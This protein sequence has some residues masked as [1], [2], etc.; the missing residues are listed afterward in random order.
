MRVVVTGGAGFIGHHLVARLLG[1]GHA[2]AILDNLRRG[3]FE[4]EGLLGAACHE[5]DVRNAEACRAVFAGAD[6]VVHLAAQSNVMG[7]ESDPDY[8]YSTNVSGTWTVLQAAAACAVK[9]VVFA[10][11]REVYGD[12]ESLPVVESAPLAPKNLYGATKAAAE[13]IVR[14]QRDIPVSVL[15][16]ANVIGAGDSGRV[17]PL[18]LAAARSDRPLYVYG[19]RQ[20]LDLVPVDFACEVLARVLTTGPLPGPLNVGT[21]TVTPIIELARKI[22][23]LTGSNS[24]IEVEPDRGP[25]VT[26]F[27]ADV[28]AL[29]T[30]L[31]LEPP[32]DPLAHVKADW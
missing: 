11:S 14:A 3:S 15:R 19:G 23:R 6:A 22:I 21:G 28:S 20:E 26:R 17:T 16:L 32:I 2:V 13:L 27:R 10:S 4:R 1:D 31:G 30:V 25:E 7:S 24:C 29:R 12:A 18:W 9:H 8:A 5:G